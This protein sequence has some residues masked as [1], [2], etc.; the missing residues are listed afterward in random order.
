[1][2]QPQQSRVV[3]GQLTADSSSPGTKLA[4]DLG[5]CPKSAEE[6]FMTSTPVGEVNWSE[7]DVAACP[8]LS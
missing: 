2:K 6:F 3:S 4:T 5:C 1:M 7:W 8:A